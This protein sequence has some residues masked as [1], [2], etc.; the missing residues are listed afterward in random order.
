M[1][2]CLIVQGCLVIKT[3]KDCLVLVC[4]QTRFKNHEPSPPV[5]SLPNKRTSPAHAPVCR[6]VPPGAFLWTGCAFA[7]HTIGKGV[8][9]CSI[10]IEIT[11]CL[12]SY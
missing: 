2:G 6:T 5:Q 1:G 7:N 8:L 3:R 12:E 10:T 11:A 9:F 4:I